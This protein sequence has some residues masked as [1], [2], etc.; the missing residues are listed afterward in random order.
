MDIGSVSALSANSASPS[1]GVKVGAKILDNQEQIAGKVIE[2][3]KEASPPRPSSSGGNLV[4]I[5]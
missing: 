3:V 1:V 4:A 2:S 5:A